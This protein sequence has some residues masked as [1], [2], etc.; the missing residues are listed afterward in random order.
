MDDVTDAE[1]DI[2][3]GACERSRTRK[4]NSGS[5]LDMKDNPGG[6]CGLETVERM[7]TRAN[8][9]SWRARTHGCR[10][11]Y[12]EQGELSVLGIAMIWREEHQKYRG[13]RGDMWTFVPLTPRKKK[14]HWIKKADSDIYR[15][16]PPVTSSDPL[17]QMQ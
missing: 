4:A 1:V 9:V 17:G 2:R 3:I 5:T 11:R 16:K 8:K 13:R 15:K 10:G 7:L 14:R 6:V 12:P